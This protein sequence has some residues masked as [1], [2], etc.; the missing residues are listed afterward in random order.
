MLGL[1]DGAIA[2]LARD[3]GTDTFHTHLGSLGVVNLKIGGRQMRIGAFL[4]AAAATMMIVSAEAEPIVLPPDKSIPLSIDAKHA[5][6][7]KTEKIAIFSDVQVSQGDMHWRCKLL[8]VRY[9]D[10]KAPQQLECEP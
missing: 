7:N 4:A 2:H 8:T 5:N 3:L 9:D 10:A 6:I 1:G